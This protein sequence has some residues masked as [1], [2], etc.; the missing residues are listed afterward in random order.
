MLVAVLLL[1]LAINAVLAWTAIA[2]PGP[3]WRKWLALT[4]LALSVP[5]ALVAVHE[6]TGRPKPIA[7]EWVHDLRGGATVVATSSRLSAERLAFYKDL[8]R[9]RARAGAALWLVPA[10]LASYTD[11][12]ALIEWIG[13]EQ[14]ENLGATTGVLKP[15]LVPTLLFPFA[16]PRVAGDLTD[17]GARAELEM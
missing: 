8:Y 11:V 3:L 1:L 17:A 12:D 9:T 16:A 5:V 10:N 2:Q 6:L 15:A 14:T 7:L 13:T 4:A